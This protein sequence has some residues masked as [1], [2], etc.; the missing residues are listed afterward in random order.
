MK[1][2]GI[3]GP[4][5]FI[6]D[7]VWMVENFLEMNPL[8]LHQNHQQNLLSTLQNLDGLI[9]LGGKDIHPITYGESVKKH[10]NLSNFDLKRDNRELF[11]IKNAIKL[12]IP[13]LGIC[14]GLQVL[15]I[16]YKLDFIMDL[17]DSEI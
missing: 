8:I 6:T 3:T 9:L 7:A 1:N 2:I 16:Y 5:T 11:L 12:K 14:R 4:S 17:S 15:G 10:H 13:V